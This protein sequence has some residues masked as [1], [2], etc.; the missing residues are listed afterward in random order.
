MLEMVRIPSGDFWMGSSEVEFDKFLSQAKQEL[1]WNKLQVE[2]FLRTYSESPQRLVTVAAGYMSKYQITQSQYELV[3]NGSKPSM[4]SGEKNLP[5]DSVS[6]FD[7]IDFC[8]K[9]SKKVGNGKT[10]TLPNEA[11][12]EYACR[13]GTQTPFNFG[14]EI[15]P[16]LANYTY[17]IDSKDKHNSRRKTTPVG[18]FDHP[19]RFGLHD[20]HGNLH[21]WCLDSW[22]HSYD[23]AP[24]DGSAWL[25]DNSQERL[26]RGGSWSDVSRDCRS[27][28]RYKNRANLRHNCN[29]FRVWLLLE[30]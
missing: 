27:A 8:E 28:Y 26:L 7:A 1:N 21:E 19:N 11:Q 20:M 24:S 4:F 16:N 29:G 23:N 12:W 10:Y 17:S 13:A 18:I 5:V 22:H 25:N 15:S 6:W 30:D 9:L 3:M 14:S 2:G